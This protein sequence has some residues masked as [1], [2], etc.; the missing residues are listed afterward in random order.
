MDYT[1]VWTG[2]RNIPRTLLDDEMHIG[3]KPT[4]PE[5]PIRSQP[6]RY[7]Y[8]KIKGRISGLDLTTIKLDPGEFPR[9]EEILQDFNECL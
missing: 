2:L 4:E 6:M 8:E 1:L 5:E 7:D 9:I 3:F